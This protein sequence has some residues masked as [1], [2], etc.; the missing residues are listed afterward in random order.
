MPV[1]SGGFEHRRE[2]PAHRQTPECRLR[3]AQD[4]ISVNGIGRRGLNRNLAPVDHKLFGKHL[5]ETRRYALPHFRHA[6]ENGHALIRANPDESTDCGLLRSRRQ[7]PAR[8]NRERE[9]IDKPSCGT[10]GFENLAATEFLGFTRMSI[11]RGMIHDVTLTFRRAVDGLSDSLIG[12]A[13]A[14]VIY[15]AVYVRIRRQWI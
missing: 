10:T 4:R 15:G 2:I 8:I 3:A 1:S 7:S 12:A 9:A 11:S 6:D 5:G 14:K 13:D